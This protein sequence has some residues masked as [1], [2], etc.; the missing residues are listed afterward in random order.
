M[1][2]A[3]TSVCADYLFLSPI[4]HL[5]RVGI[6]PPNT[7]VV[8]H[9]IISTVLLMMETWLLVPGNESIRAKA[10]DPLMVPAAHIT[11]S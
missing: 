9:T 4:K 8:I 7:I 1:S 6:I 11:A 2:E 3:D 5:I 10:T